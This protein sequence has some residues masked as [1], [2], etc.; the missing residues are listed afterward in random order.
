[1]WYSVD[2]YD[3]KFEYKQEKHLSVLNEYD[4]L[5][6]AEHCAEDYHS[7]HD[8]WEASWPLNISLYLSETGSEPVAVFEVEREA[9]PVFYTRKIHHD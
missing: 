1:M 8:S 6:L 9:R 3:Y 4:Q 5:A 7:N 2:D